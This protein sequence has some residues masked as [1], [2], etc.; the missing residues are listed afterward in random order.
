MADT[1]DLTTVEVTDFIEESEEYDT[2]YKRTAKWNPSTG[3][4]VR[5]GAH[6]MV[7]CEGEEGYMIWCY[8]VA[9]TERYRCLAYPDEIGVEMEDA[10][11]DDEPEIVESRVERTI[12]EALMMNPRTE[13]VGDFEFTW[14]G[15]EMHV[16]FLVTAKEWDKTFQ[17]T[18]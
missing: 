16:S 3:D 9:Q 4:F 14:D 18:L 13:S 1:T 15:D 10:M 5:D 11:S 7:E 6:R 12:T 17:I 2:E 8:K